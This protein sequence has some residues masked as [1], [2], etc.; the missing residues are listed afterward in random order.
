[1]LAQL[2]AKEG[3]AVKKDPEKSFRWYL[4]AADS[5]NAQAEMAVARAY[6]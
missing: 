1:M 2:Y 6:A 3:R 4:A 5:G